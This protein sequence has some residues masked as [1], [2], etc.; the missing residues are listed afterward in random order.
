LAEAVEVRLRDHFGV[1][2]GVEIVALGSLDGLTG[3]E[4][5]KPKRFMDQ[6]PR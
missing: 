6:R 3:Q 4:R 2:I 5:G 1:R